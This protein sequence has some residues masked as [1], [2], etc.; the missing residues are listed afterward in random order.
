M[1]SDDVAQRDA[2]QQLCAQYV[3]DA[4]AKMPAANLLRLRVAEGDDS[5]AQ[6]TP[7]RHCRRARV[8]VYSCVA[9]V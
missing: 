7:V 3:P 8:R 9:D 2:V 6:L 1:V 5:D 4:I